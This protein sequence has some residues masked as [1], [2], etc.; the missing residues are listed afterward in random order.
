[1]PIGAV[2]GSV[3]DGEGSCSAFGGLGDETLQQRHQFAGGFSIQ[4]ARTSQQRRS[5]HWLVTQRYAQR[6]YLQVPWAAEAEAQLLTLSAVSEQGTLGTLGVRLDSVHGLKCEE[7]FGPEIAELRRSG[8]RLCEFTQLAL[9]HGTTS[10]PVLAA[11]FQSAHLFAYRLQGVEL[12]VIEVNPRHVGYY[13]RMLDFQVCSDVRQNP[14]VNAPAV[15]M[16]LDLVYGQSR[17]DALAGT[18]PLGSRSLYPHFQADEGERQLLDSLRA[19][20]NAMA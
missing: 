16:C 3:D 6:G 11:L 2:L 18:C 19:Q 4:L 5:A 20:L 9:D 7:S 15:L 8:R 12:L 13:R 17:I 1:M 14:R 10:L